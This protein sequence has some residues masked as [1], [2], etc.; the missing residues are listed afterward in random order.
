MAIAGG[1]VH[2]EVERFMRRKQIFG[3]LIPLGI[4]AY[5]VYAHFAFDVSGL[6][7]RAKPERALT[8]I[9]DMFTH[10]VVVTKDNRGGDISVAVEGERTSTYD[11]PP[12]WAR[13]QGDTADIDL[14]DGYSVQFLPDETLFHVPDYGTIRL[15]A[16]RRK[17]IEA[18]YPRGKA[19]P[20]WASASK[21]RFDARP[22]GRRL[23]ATKARFEAHRRFWGWEEFFFTVN[24]PLYGKSTLEVVRTALSPDRIDPEISNLHFITRSFLGNE[25][26]LHRD[27]IVALYE[28]ILMAFLGTAMA[29]IAALPLAFLAARNFTPSQAG[30]FGLR[31]LF[32]FFRGVDGLIWTILLSRAFGPG[33]MTGTLA[34][35]VRDTG[36]FGKLFSEALE[37]VDNKQIEGV[38]STGAGPLQRYS[39]GVIPQILP[40]LI[41]QSLYYLESNSRS[42]T[43]IGAIVDAGIGILLIQAINTHKDWENVTYYVVLIILMVTLMDRVSGWLRR[44]L[45]A[46]TPA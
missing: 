10:K 18:T 40:V 15:T 13:V 29:A 32:D 2:Q 4:I 34:M 9:S 26:W 41:S 17:G 36:T 7:D 25:T 24:N 11:T 42:A 27:V 45:I 21:T 22:G 39:F 1:A 35:G 14:G 6:I 23:V 8:L 33:P 19:P 12:E 30:R 3:L 5:L 43:V 16:D 37:N 46:G 20:D 38:E 28:T 31:R 44:R